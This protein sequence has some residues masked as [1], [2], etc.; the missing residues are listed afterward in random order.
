[1]RTK[2]LIIFYI[3][4]TIIFVN[5]R[6]INA[7]RKILNKPEY[8]IKFS[9]R[10]KKINK[11][12][13]YKLQDGGHK[14]V[15]VQEGKKYEQ[16]E[17]PTTLLDVIVECSVKEASNENEFQ[18]LYTVHNSKKSKQSFTYLGIEYINEVFNQNIPVKSDWWIGKRNHCLKENRSKTVI[19]TVYDNRKWLIWGARRSAIIISGTSKGFFSF[20]SNGLPGIVYC[21]G[22]GGQDGPKWP[23]EPDEEIAKA[24]PRSG[25]DIL[26][27]KTVGA[28]EWFKTAEEGLKRLEDYAEESF[29]QGWI[30]TEV[31]KNRILKEIGELKKIVLSNRTLEIKKQSIENFMKNIQK[32][33]DEKQI[34]SETFALI[35]YNSRALIKILK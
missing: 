22:N 31:E 25:K 12:E 14:I 15:W 34:L 2:I 9:E 13:V 10:A 23:V 21:I 18:F 27:G 28:V 4:I 1:M 29:V 8:K 3:I 33:Y 26:Y 5:I 32:Y 24:R 17:Y 30:E 20:E 7:E 11:A 6:Q 16:I 35:Y 19:G